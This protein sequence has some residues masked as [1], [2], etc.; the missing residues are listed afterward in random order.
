MRPGTQRPIV[1]VPLNQ[2]EYSTFVH[3]SRHEVIPRAEDP[4]LSS[5][6]ELCE[7][8]LKID[9]EAGLRPPLPPESGTPDNRF[10]FQRKIGQG[11]EGIVYAAVPSDQLRSSDGSS[12]GSTG[13]YRKSVAIKV[14]TGRAFERCRAMR[15]LWPSLVHPNVVYPR[16]AY[17]DNTNS[18]CFL[19]MELLATDLLDDIERKG[20]LEDSR[21][22]EVTGFLAAALDH[23]HRRGVA[24]R[25]VKL[26]NVFVQDEA[27]KLGD[28]GG[29]TH[30]HH[31]SVT[32]V[33]T[34]DQD[35]GDSS[36]ASTT[37]VAAA[38]AKPPSSAAAAQKVPELL[39]S[40][41]YAPPESVRGG[42]LGSGGG[43]NRRDLLAGDMWS[44]GV[45]LY[46]AV[47]GCHPWEV[48]SE[49]SKEFRRFLK[50][51]AAAIMLKGFSPGAACIILCQRLSRALSL[52]R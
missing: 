19:E 31:S 48:A 40:T 5:A 46:S 41:I 45:T 15:H 12:S 11:A 42:C 27:V 36:P 9:L 7:M 13:E 3:R 6:G 18:R 17:F 50:K 44:L 34:A 49:T 47:A 30:V 37:S 29:I 28:L 1:Y 20:N 52:E 51:G 39:G 8:S 23:L 22:S 14:I 10:I 25:D 16:S 38:E 2:Y 26:E 21:A 24:H 33:P 43:I 4:Q 35:F 32:T